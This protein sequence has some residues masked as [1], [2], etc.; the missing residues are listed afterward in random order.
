MSAP[1]VLFFNFLF[2]NHILLSSHEN[3]WGLLV[4]ACLVL[5]SVIM[6]PIMGYVSDKLDRFKLLK[7]TYFLLAIFTIPLYFLFTS[8][9]LLL[10]FFS[11]FVFG[12]FVCI[13]VATFP[14]IIVYQSSSLCRVSTVG[15]SH[16]LSVVFGSF[17][18]SINELFKNIT[19]TEIAPAFVIMICCVL[20]F[21]MLFKLSNEQKGVTN[22]S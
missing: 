12:V 15:I 10:M 1:V 19:N 2:H 11:Y 21:F 17:I 9:H 13:S 16:S 14:A 6:L 3:S 5:F 7:L 20:S 18:P 4:Q 8:G 22:A